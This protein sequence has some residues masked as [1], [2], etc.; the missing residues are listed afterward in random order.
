MIFLPNLILFILIAYF[1]WQYRTYSGNGNDPYWVKKA[2]R[3]YLYHSIS[4]AVFF[5]Y[6]LFIVLFICPD[7]SKS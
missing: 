2:K 7:S 1:R 4:W 6:W 5:L 3:A